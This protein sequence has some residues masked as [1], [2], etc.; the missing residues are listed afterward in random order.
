MKKISIF[1]IVF[2][3]LTFSQFNRNNNSLSGRP[4]FYVNRFYYGELYISSK[5]SSNAFFFYKLPLSRMLFEKSG[6]I[7]KAKL[8]VSLEILDDKNNAIQREFDE[9][10]VEAKS[11]DLTKSLNDYVEGVIPITYS[12][13]MK[14]ILPALIDV[15]SERE[16]RGKAIR[17]DNS[18]IGEIFLAP[19]VVKKNMY[20]CNGI[21]TYEL[22]NFKGDFPFS[23]NRYKI[24]FPTKNLETDELYVKIK[25][26]GKIVFNKSIDKS[27]KG[28]LDFIYCN[29]K[30]VLNNA[31]SEVEYQFF[32]LENIDKKLT[33][34]TLKIQISTSPDFS[35][36][37]TY[38][39]KV[40][41]F[42]KPFSLRN[43]E[44][45]IKNLKFIEK[46]SVIDNLLDNE[47]YQYAKQLQKYWKKFDPTPNTAYN[48][49]MKEY[50]ERIDY[51]MRHFSPI[52]RKSGANTDRGKIYIRYGKPNK[53]TRTSNTYGQVTEIWIY[54]KTKKEFVFIDKFGIGDFSLVTG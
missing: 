17:V 46:D 18:K 3:C 40:T 22:A 2:S 30:I 28:K 16:L 11:Y 12:R 33:E 21:D 34:G 49:I 44:L 53:I 45:A 25:S 24:L 41:W 19:I 31:D 23:E 20:E 50:Y 43:P 13:K 52:N 38:L 51:S 37:F 47:S 32:I 15:F 4:A 1:I 27:F 7:Y 9:K 48:P 42:D 6:D 36:S 54:D 14:K 26:N 8:R 35:N 39:K 5:D 29:G 10:L